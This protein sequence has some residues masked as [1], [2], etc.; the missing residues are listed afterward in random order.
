MSSTNH[1]ALQEADSPLQEYTSLSNEETFTIPAAL[2]M[3]PSRFRIPKNPSIVDKFKG[4]DK[5]KRSTL[6][7]SLKKGLSLECIKFL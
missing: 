5:E 3:A 4:K 7:D 6:S 2:S 1:E